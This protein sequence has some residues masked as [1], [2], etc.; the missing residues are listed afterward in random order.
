MDWRPSAASLYRVLLYAYPADFR[1]EYGSEMEC[2]FRERLR[3][4]PVTQVWFDAL[5]DACTGAPKE[6]FY[7]LLQDLRYG[8]RTLA[9]TPAFTF[10]AILTAA[11]GI[12][13]TTAVFSL[14]NTVLLRS[15]PYQDASRLV[16]IWSPNSNFKPPIPKEIEPGNADFYDWQRLSRS[17]TQM[18]GFHRINLDYGT[19][20]TIDRINGVKVTGDFFETLGVAPWMGRTIDAGD[21]RPGHERVAV[22]SHGF[23]QAKLASSPSVLEDHVILNGISYRIVG[24]MPPGFEFPRNG[25]VPYDKVQATRVW[26]PTAFS[27]EERSVRE[28]GENRVIARLAPGVSVKQAQ[29]EMSAIAAQ[30]DRKHQEQDRGWGAYIAPL[31]ETVVGPVRLPML[32]L[33]GAV[34]LVLAIASMNVANLLIARASG[35]VHEI[36]VRAALGA[37]RGRLIRQMVTESLLLAIGGGLLGVLLAVGGV[38]FLVRLNPGN[39]PRI[40]ETSLDARV[41][42][43]AAAISAGTGVLFG[44]L[45]A[46]SA[47]R[48][49]VMP[50]LK[51][52]GG[53]GSVAASSRLRQALIVAEVALSVLLL[54]S[55]GL[56]IRSDLKLQTDGP[57]FS[58]STLTTRIYPPDRY[59][60]VQRAEL[61]RDLMV[62]LSGV[63]GVQYAGASGVLPF[64]EH[65]SATYVQFEDYP[66]EPKQLMYSTTASPEYFRAMGMS[67]SHGR[68]FEERDSQDGPDAVIVNQAFAQKFFPGGS[69]LGRHLRNS[70][71]GPWWTVVGEIANAHFDK[72]EE[73]PEPML[74]T[75][76]GTHPEPSVFIAIRSSLPPGQ[77]APSVRKVIRDADASVAVDTFSTMEDRTSEPWAR[78]HFQTGLFSGFAGVALALAL[79][80][81][82]GLMAFI[83]KLRTAEVGIRIALGATPGR[84]LGLILRQGL[85]MT[86]PGIALGL[87]GAFAVTRFLASW[88]YG[89]SA[90]DPL[91]FA[92]TPLLLLL[93]ATAACLIP[94]WRATRINPMLAL[95]SE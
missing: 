16:Y 42:L 37:G 8:M 7:I 93:V 53:K 9:A 66:Q 49:D 15:L 84:V 2:V 52:G 32:L 76:L 68:F 4:E 75:L 45:P 38:R 30:T 23:W 74:Y 24:V 81:L 77:L 79:V 86:V 28:S 12:G 91:T 46:L 63:P 26:I 36:G 61:Y 88:L 62:R 94:A 11:L 92:A 31:T 39:I 64:G 60:T 71:D 80:G 51:Q 89:V 67:L 95:R 35:R 59:S 54:A 27:P 14:V 6:H 44:L 17:F 56:L 18:A 10:F 20:D 58:A 48:T 21:D 73:K 78:R 82:Y 13:S 22:I 69:A 65:H 40:T 47:T 83:V 85:G 33:L 50:L 1:E 5:F 43:F 29:Q 72:L 3:S 90:E 57:G 19:G 87:A 34:L 70:P 25:E 55:C 41:L